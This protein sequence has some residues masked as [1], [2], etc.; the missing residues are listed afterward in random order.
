MQKWQKLL[1]LEGIADS[2][3]ED[4]REAYGDASSPE[5]KNSTSSQENASSS[6]DSD[7]KTETKPQPDTVSTDS[8]VSMDSGISSG[9]SEGEVDTELIYDKPKHLNQ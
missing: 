7:N 3:A 9:N 2:T 1:Y 5:K 6:S 8:G 4:L